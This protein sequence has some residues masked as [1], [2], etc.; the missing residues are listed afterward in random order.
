MRMEIVKNV[1]AHAHEYAQELV[2][3]IFAM[4]NCAINALRMKLGL[5][6]NVS[7]MQFL[8]VDNVSAK[9]GI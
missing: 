2:L 7:R 1:L 4:K 8:A 9:V 5:A 3:A 6:L